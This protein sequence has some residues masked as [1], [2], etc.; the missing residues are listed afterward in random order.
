MFSD[1]LDRCLHWYCHGLDG[2]FCILIFH[3]TRNADN[4][5]ISDR[6]EETYRTLHTWFPEL[7]QIYHIKQITAKILKNKHT[8]KFLFFLV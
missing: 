2:V 8:M 4:T 5:R 1:D 7:S 6:H 3:P